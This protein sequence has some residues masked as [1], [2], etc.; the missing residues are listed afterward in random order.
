MNDD[1]IKKILAQGESIS[2]EFKECRT[3]ISKTVYETVCSFLNRIGG[4]LLLGVK[5]NGNI[6]GIDER[7][8]EKLK[9]DFVTSI[10]NFQKI[11]PTIYLSPEIIKIDGKYIIYI[12]IPESSQVHR[13]NGKIYDR[14]QDGDFDITNNTNL[15]GALYLRKQTNFSENIVYPYLTMN[16]FKPELI[17]RARKIAS[18]QKPDHPWAFMT[19][20][21]LLKSARLFQKDWQT[22]KDGFTLAAALLLGREDVVLSIVP[23]N[24]SF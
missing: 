19:D 15:V 9:D 3:E 14:N 1:Q 20:E 13:C 17:A 6:T 24:R 10:N 8:I 16:E 21:E 22:G 18:I 4:E 11:N 23:H 2:V 5:D 7:F 12:H